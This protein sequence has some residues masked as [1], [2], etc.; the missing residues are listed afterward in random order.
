ME[1]VMSAEHTFDWWRRG[2]L[3]IHEELLDETA[4]LIEVFLERRP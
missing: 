4:P 3:G 2:A 1:A